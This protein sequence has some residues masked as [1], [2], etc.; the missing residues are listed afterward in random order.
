[1][2]IN[3]FYIFFFN[4]MKLYI[5]SLIA[6]HCKYKKYLH[7]AGNMLISLPITIRLPEQEKANENWRQTQRKWCPFPEQT[8][9]MTR[10]HTHIL[11][12]EMY[13]LLKLTCAQ[14]FWKGFVFKLIKL[15]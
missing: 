10:T 13:L 1:M 6:H 15:D 12:L 5:A 2:H 14:V 8:D 9:Q 4:Y 3:V 11:P 7:L